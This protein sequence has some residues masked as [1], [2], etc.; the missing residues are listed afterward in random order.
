[1]FFFSSCF[2]KYTFVDSRLGLVHSSGPFVGGELHGDGCE[3]RLA[4][5]RV[6]FSGRM[7]QG[8]FK[9]GWWR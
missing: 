1:L 5:G 3:W 2:V 7:E 6:F 8:R 4:S 9:H